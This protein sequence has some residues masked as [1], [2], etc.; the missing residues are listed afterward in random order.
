MT[1]E[2]GRT[3]FLCLILDIVGKYFL[4]WNSK[5][6]RNAKCQFQRRG[7]FSLFHGNDGLPRHA[8]FLS[9][10]L[11]GHLVVKKTQFPDVVVDP[12]FAHLRILCDKE[13][14]VKRRPESA[15]ALQR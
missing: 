7:V 4:Q 12:T 1:Y 2:N 15:L 8:R 14:A 3:L 11:L 10:L 9:Q 5:S 13:P 6:K